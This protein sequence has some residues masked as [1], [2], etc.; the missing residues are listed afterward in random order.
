MTRSA[1]SGA[2][3]AIIFYASAACHTMRPIPA[4]ALGAAHAWPKIWVTTAPDRATVILDAPALRGDTLYGFVDETY[5][6]MPLSEV[7]AIHAREGARTRTAALVGGSLVAMTGLLVYFGNRSY[8][9][10]NATTCSSGN[11]TG[12]V[13]DNLPVPCCRVNPTIPC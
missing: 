12:D 5:R 6:E 1:L 11:T 10:G 3:G 4:T 7:T 9:G 2:A 13:A 8:V